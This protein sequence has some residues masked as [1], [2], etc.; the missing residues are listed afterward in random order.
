[1]LWINFYKWLL[2]FVHSARGLVVSFTNLDIVSS[3][4]VESWIVHNLQT[5]RFWVDS[6]LNEYTD[7]IAGEQVKR[8]LPSSWICLQYVS[9][10]PVTVAAI[11]VDAPWTENISTGNLIIIRIRISLIN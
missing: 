1:M 5:S 7:Y 3:I 10:V 6:I 11:G 8:C 9:L 2:E 4:L